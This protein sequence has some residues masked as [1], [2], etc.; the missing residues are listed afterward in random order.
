M[1]SVFSFALYGSADKYC[2]GMLRNVELI[3]SEFPDW[4]IW[5]AVGTG[6]PDSI[7]QELQSYAFVKLHFTNETGA[8]NMS[9]RF[10][11]IDNENVSVCCVRDADSRVFAR[12]ASCVKDFVNSDKLF[13]IVRDH[14]NHHHRIMGCSF[15][16]K[17][18]VLAR[19]LFDIFQEYRKTHNVNEFWN[20]MEFIAAVFYP[21]VLAY[22]MIHDDLQEFE[23]DSMKTTFKVSVGD[24][25]DF[26]GQVYEFDENGQEYAKYKDYLEGGVYGKAFWTEKRIQR[27][28]NY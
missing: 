23:S 25:L 1:I 21:H 28:R 6:V 8:I 19:P 22:S 11:P 14:P 20:D 12:D 15:G 9:Y 16:I 27:I 17:K 7:L 18:G 3:H 24:G 26:V 4:Q 13:H 10:F 5:I 2:K